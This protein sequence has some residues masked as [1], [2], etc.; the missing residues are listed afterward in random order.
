MLLGAAGT[1]RAWD[2]TL[3]CNTDES[4]PGM[5][6]ASDTRTLIFPVGRAADFWVTFPRLQVGGSPGSTIEHLIV[7]VNG[8]VVYDESYGPAELL[9]AGWTRLPSGLAQRELGEQYTWPDG[10]H[11]RRVP[12]KLPAVPGDTFV[13][14]LELRGRLKVEYI[15]PARPE[16]GVRR[17]G[18][19]CNNF[20][21][22][23]QRAP[24]FD[25]L[26][27]FSTPAKF[28]LFDTG[29]TI[30]FDRAPD[31]DVVWTS[32]TPN[33]VVFDDPAVQDFRVV[34]GPGLARVQA[35]FTPRSDWPDQ[36]GAPVTR[37]LEF[38]VHDIE[39]MTGPPAVPVGGTATFHLQSTL[40]PITWFVDGEAAG[41]GPTLVWQAPPDAPEI[42]NVS[43]VVSNPPPPSYYFDYYYPQ[44]QNLLVIGPRRGRRSGRANTNGTAATP[45]SGLCTVLHHNGDNR[46]TRTDL[47]V[48]GGVS[49]VCRYFS[50]V[51]TPDGPLGFNWDANVFENLTVDAATGD[52]RHLLLGREDLWR[53]NSDGSYVPPFDV[54]DTLLQRSDG[55]FVLRDP[56]GE[57]RFFTAAGK[58]DRIEDR[59][60][61]QT[62]YLYRDDGT[63][64]RTLDRFGRPVDFFFTA[65]RLTLVRAFDGREVLYGYDDQG[66]L[67]SVRSPVLASSTGD[68]FPEGRTER[69]AYLSGRHE[70]LNHILRAPQHG[71]AGRAR[72]RAHDL[73]VLVDPYAGDVGGLGRAGRALLLDE[74]PAVPE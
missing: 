68:D 69:Y 24:F 52:V 63:L 32:L 58:L 37:T 26:N 50:R 31:G 46:Y 74:V 60:G 25:N 39:L 43:V 17:G 9:P 55:S 29:G 47:V 61:N 48:E 12:P 59:H 21:N 4:V 64:E 42:V 16:D 35:V 1:A 40:G 71:R 6:E 27:L 54:F 51:D 15:D 66:D 22:L 49:L 44:G 53:R 18:I 33:L 30:S 38:F 13:V 41:T 28:P 5:Y 56:H 3:T 7:R 62:L 65:G 11:W 23:S 34:S 19:G 45:G 72:A 20:G 10:V 67:T 73:E 14:E 2:E 57:K 8:T 36:T 70:R